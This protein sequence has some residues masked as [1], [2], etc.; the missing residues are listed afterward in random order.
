MFIAGIGTGGTISGIGRYLKGNNPNTLVY[1]VEPLNSNI[2]N[3][4]KV[5]PHLIQGI[6]ANFIPKNLDQNIIDA[7]IDVSDE[8]A[9][10]TA[11]LLMKYEGIAVGI[12]S[13]AAMFGALEIA[14][15]PE[16]QGKTIVVILPDTAERYLS[17]KLFDI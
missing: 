3:N 1:G 8:D 13:G 10:E 9:I 14:K 5:G 11:K 16:M 15:K 6:G 17:T 12:S 7:Y 2:L 4:G